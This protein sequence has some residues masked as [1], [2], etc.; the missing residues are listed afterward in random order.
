MWKRQNL[1]II[2]ISKNMQIFEV[3]NWQIK[4]R[5]NSASQVSGKKMRVFFREDGMVNSFRPL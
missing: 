1:T 4:F 5:Q 3:C 2:S